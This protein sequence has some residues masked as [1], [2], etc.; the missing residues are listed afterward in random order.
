MLYADHRGARHVRTYTISARDREATAGTCIH[1]HIVCVCMS[2]YMDV[3]MHVHVWTGRRW[4]GTKVRLSGGI[5][6]LP[7]GVVVE[8]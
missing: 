5:R 4:K 8:S 1:I 2:V 3:H 6:W 7:D